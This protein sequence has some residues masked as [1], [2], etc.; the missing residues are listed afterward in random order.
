MLPGEAAMRATILASLAAY[1]AAEYLWFRHRAVAFHA[2]ALLWTA[3]AALCIVHAAIAFE[4]RHDWSH[5]AAWAQTAAQT[6]AV[7]GL[8]WGGG[9]YV[10]YAFLVLWAAD[11][12]WLWSSPRS[13]LH[14]PAVISTAVSAFVL[15]M[16]INGAVVFV[17]GPARVAGAIAVAVVMWAWWRGR[18]KIVAA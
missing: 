11:V 14:R 3:A 18:D 8:D 4:V 15:F 10:N 9:L 17:R 6:A 2:R 13:Y 1:A 7:T 5:D 16:F 12:V